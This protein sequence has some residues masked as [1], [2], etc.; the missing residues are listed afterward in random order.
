MIEE[1][2]FDSWHRQ[3]KF[4]LPYNIQTGFGDHPASYLTGTGGVSLRVKWQGHEADHSPP[5]SAEVK[6]GKS[7]PP[8]LHTSSQHCA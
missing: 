2:V 8:L 1:F 3:E 6:N 4:S 7:I 5:S